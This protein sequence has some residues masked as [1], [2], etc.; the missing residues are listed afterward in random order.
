MSDLLK[1]KSCPAKA[2]IFI[3]RV[4]QKCLSPFLPRTCRFYP[5]CSNYAIQALE[6]HG[7]FAGLYKALTRLLRCNPFH[8][9]GYD[10]V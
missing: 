4:Y 6:K 7:F 8:P 5:S 3:I 2:L 9:G 10:P 1:I